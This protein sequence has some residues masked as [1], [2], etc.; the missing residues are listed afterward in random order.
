MASTRLT[1]TMRESI[2][3]AILSATFDKRQTELLQAQT[4]LAHRIYTI[5]MDVEFLVAA[6][7]HPE[8]FRNHQ[9]IVVSIDGEKLQWWA[10]EGTERMP[11]SSGLPFP[12]S[13]SFDRLGYPKI[14]LNSNEDG[15]EHFDLALEVITHHKAESDFSDQRFKTKRD[16]WAL[17]EGLST[18]EKFMEAAP[19]LVDYLP[20]HIRQAGTKASL[21]MVQAGN[22]IA[23][24][25]EA[26]LKIPKE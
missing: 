12:A 7:N 20:D 23:G 14:S 11:L 25:M 16:L 9:S 18:L 24:L 19:E 3:H 21:P 26:G 4:K 2:L 6:K 10:R 13:W 1:K 15:N 22:V 17:L 8:W 5:V